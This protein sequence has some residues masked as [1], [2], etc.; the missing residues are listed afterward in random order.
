M[1]CFGSESKRL[2]PE[3]ARA[4]V[5]PFYDA[6]NQPATKDVAALVGRAALP[7]WRSFSGEGV[8]KSREEFIAQV[9]VLGTASPCI[10]AVSRHRGPGF[11]LQLLC[12]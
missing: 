6:L 4:I 7:D 2:T 3:A 1:D 11:L 10:W 5:A 12:S 9:M 8:S